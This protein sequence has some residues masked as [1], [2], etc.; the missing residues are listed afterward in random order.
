MD[1]KE[2][3]TPSEL[4]AANSTKSKLQLALDATV[5]LGGEEIK[6]LALHLLSILGEAHDAMAESELKEGRTESAFAWS[7]DEAIIHTA[8]DLVKSIEL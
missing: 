6:S 4:L 2:I 1:L 5:E 3:S 7:K 8:W